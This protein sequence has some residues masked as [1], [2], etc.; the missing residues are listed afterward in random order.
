MGLT[1]TPLV[2]KRSK[3]C[4][5]H[6]SCE[7][8]QCNRME[9]QLPNSVSLGPLPGH[10]PNMVKGCSENLYFDPRNSDCVPNKDHLWPKGKIWCE[11]RPP[12]DISDGGKCQ[13]RSRDASN[14]K[15]TTKWKSNLEDNKPYRHVNGLKMV[16]DME[17][18]YDLGDCEDITTKDKEDYD[19]IS[20]C[21]ASEEFEDRY[22]E[23]KGSPHKSNCPRKSKYHGSKF[24]QSHMEDRY[25]KKETKSF[26]DHV[27][28][29]L[30]KPD[31]PRDA[32][33]SIS[34]ESM[35]NSSW[36]CKESK[37]N[38]Q[39][40][41]RDNHMPRTF[42]LS[43]NQPQR[44]CPSCDSKLQGDDAEERLS[45]FN[46]CSSNIINADRMNPRSNSYPCTCI[47]IQ[48]PE[49]FP[50]MIAYDKQS[51]MQQTFVQGLSSRNS[52]NQKYPSTYSK[53][54]TSTKPPKASPFGNLEELQTQKRPRNLS[55]TQKEYHNEID[56]ESQIL[57]SYNASNKRKFAKSPEKDQSSFIPVK[58][59]LFENPGITR[60]SLEDQGKYTNLI[61][62]TSYKS[63]LD[64]NSLRREQKQQHGIYKRH[65]ISQTETENPNYGKKRNYSQAHI[66]CDIPKS[67]THIPIRRVNMSSQ[68]ENLRNI[69]SLHKDQSEERHPSYYTTVGNPTSDP[70]KFTPYSYLSPDTC[71]CPGD[72]INKFSNF[73]QKSL[74]TF[75]KCCSKLFHIHDNYTKELDLET[76]N[77][78]PRILKIQGTTENSSSTDNEPQSQCAICCICG[79][80]IS[81]RN[82]EKLSQVTCNSL[83]DCYSNEKFIKCCQ[84]LASPT[85]PEA[86]EISC[87][88]LDMGFL[89]T[90]H[91]DNDS[92]SSFYFK[93]CEDNVEEILYPYK[94]NDQETKIGNIF[95]TSTEFENKEFQENEQDFFVEYSVKDFPR[96]FDEDKIKGKDNG[97]LGTLRNEM[98]EQTEYNMGQFRILL[99]HLQKNE[100]KKGN[101]QNQRSNSINCHNKECQC[102]IYP[103]E[104]NSSK[105]RKCMIF[106]V[107]EFERIVN[108]DQHY[109]NCCTKRS[110]RCCGNIQHGEKFHLHNPNCKCKGL[111]RNCGGEQ[112][113]NDAFEKNI[114]NKGEE[115]L[116]F[117]DNHNGTGNSVTPNKSSISLNMDN[118]NGGINSVTFIQQKD[119]Y[120]NASI[121][122]ADTLSFDL[123]TQNSLALNDSIPKHRS[124][125][126]MLQFLNRFSNTMQNDLNDDH[127]TSGYATEPED[128]FGEMVF[129]KGP[130][131]KN[132]IFKK[133]KVN[134]EII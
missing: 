2:P 82:I 78:H 52:L 14:T 35:H 60:N 28:M 126:N 41:E 65:T 104:R 42:Q 15:M 108:N 116:T 118:Q 59:K 88:S 73:V 72:I 29:R 37:L 54:R 86:K 68:T 55:G 90:D 100:M 112:I 3:S 110:I 89:N 85:K 131:C 125:D 61:A 80:D 8:L 101:Q 119:N 49:S 122:I 129:T 134:G 128:N 95:T 97:N 120:N 93:D 117:V 27:T 31:C 71:L 30:R 7:E 66:N 76:S 44:L 81:K 57:L 83:R 48:N 53:S 19:N 13:W 62:R 109:S 56:N 121:P 123:H 47:M 38:Y 34:Y 39:Q 74:D 6:L 22:Q 69:Q 40:N 99:D 64:S 50:Q 23:S 45:K 91:W 133:S 77:H 20:Y 130:R 113:V 115:Y 105:T 51:E 103:T 9:Y 46:K 67:K 10:C 25:S 4:P 17:S 26:Q 75:M 5:S 106:D 36:N 32:F 102:E 79:G 127:E 11:C 96:N 94:A 33:A 124:A 21:S 18:Q 87:Q 43:A 114:D 98:T 70:Y 12:C 92:L 107:E 63:Q 24:F 1:G 84:F 16:A 132:L 58:R 111:S